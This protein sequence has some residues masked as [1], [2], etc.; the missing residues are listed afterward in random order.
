MGSLYVVKPDVLSE[1][2]DISS[3]NAEYAVDDN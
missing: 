3:L 1:N 2:A